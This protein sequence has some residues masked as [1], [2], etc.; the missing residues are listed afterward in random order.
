LNQPATIAAA[1][2]GG[3]DADLRGDTAAAVDAGPVA[4]SLLLSS[5]RTLSWCWSASGTREQPAWYNIQSERLPR[6]ALYWGIKLRPW[7]HASWAK[8][9]TKETHEITWLAVVQPGG[10]RNATVSVPG[11]RRPRKSHLKVLSVCVVLTDWWRLLL[12]RLLDEEEDDEEVD[13]D[14]LL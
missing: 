8:T 2:A 4:L 9:T 10:W 7:Q 6:S 3:D 1:L 14:D 13:E 11:V 5:N 12:R